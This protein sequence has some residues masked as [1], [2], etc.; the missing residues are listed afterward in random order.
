MSDTQLKINDSQTLIEDLTSKLKEYEG[1]CKNGDYK[2]ASQVANS[3]I[4]EL[5]KKLREKSSEIEVYKTKCSR[6]EVAL[7]Q[8][9]DISENVDKIGKYN[10]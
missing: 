4:I 1:Q 6:L 8:L 2:S 10:L 5:S 3:K 9:K 7:A